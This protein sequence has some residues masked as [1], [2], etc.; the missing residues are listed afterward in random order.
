MPRKRPRVRWEG[1]LGVWPHVVWYGERLDKGGVCYLRWW[2]PSRTNWQWESCRTKV[3]TAAGALSAGHQDQVIEL[4]KRRHDLLLGHI[5][6][7]PRAQLAPITLRQT[8]AVITEPDSGRFPARTP[9]RDSL[10][11]AIDD[12]TKVLGADFAWLHFDEAAFTRVT[13]RKVHDARKR[14]HTGY[15]AAVAL[16]TSLITLMGLLREAKRLPANIAIPGGRRWRKD[17]LR[18]VADLQGGIEPEIQRP[19]HSA[20]EMRAIIGRAPLVDPRFALMI[21]LGAELRLG[22]V[23]RARRSHLDMEKGLFRTPGRGD[24]RGALVELT[25]G[26]LVAVRGALAG[27]LAPME[28]AL[29]DYPLFPQGML[30]KELAQPERH[31]SAEPIDKRTV[32]AW[33]V[34]AEKLAGVAHV[35]GRAAYGLRRRAVDEAIAAGITPDGL[36]QLGGWSSDRMPQTIYRDKNREIARGEAAAQRAR[37]RGEDVPV[38]YPA[39]PTGHTRQKP[40]RHK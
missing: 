5:T 36:Q 14:G 34:A 33:F 23:R 1:R 17:L 7:D 22:Q 20:D 37:I 30:L 8:W 35:K 15:R 4:A 38:S 18:F 29:P 28:A 10:E 21:A 26:Q 9:Y 39:P 13:R 32:N 40:A 24:K 3:R 31:G 12:A 25:R 19:R 11:T 6:E 2:V 16:G 27:Y